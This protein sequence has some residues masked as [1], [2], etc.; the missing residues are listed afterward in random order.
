MAD[1][2]CLGTEVKLLVNIEAD[3]FS[4]DEDDF[5]IVLK[6]GNR[7]LV[8]QKAD[9]YHDGEDY[10]IRFD[11]TDLGSGYVDAIVTAYVPDPAFEIEGNDGYRTEVQKLEKILKI[12]GV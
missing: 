2:I 7:E 3:G 8:F 5:N 4:M 6:R 1:Y 12:C 11:S 10:I 9:L